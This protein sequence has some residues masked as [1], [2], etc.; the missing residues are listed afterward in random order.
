MLDR[1]RLRC[2]CCR[3]ENE[4]QQHRHHHRKGRPER[5]RGGRSERAIRVDGC[6]HGVET[7][8]AL[9]LFRAIS[10]QMFLVIDRRQYGCPKSMSGGP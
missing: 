3:K 1:R 8:K 9:Q 7:P 10:D 5:G 4:D 2:E 6:V